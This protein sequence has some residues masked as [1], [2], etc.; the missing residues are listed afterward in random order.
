FLADRTTTLRFDDYSSQE[1]YP[2]PTGVPQG[3]PLSVILYLIYSAGLLRTGDGIMGR[4]DMTLGYI[5][6]TAYVVVG[7]SVHE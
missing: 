3:S 4:A 7:D 1:A 2:V 6:D 5:D